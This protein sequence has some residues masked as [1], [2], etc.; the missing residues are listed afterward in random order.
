MSDKHFSSC[1]VVELGIQIEK[2]GKDFYGKLARMAQSKQASEVF[3]YLSEEEEK[4]IDIFK[5]IFKASCRYE[6][7]GAYPEDYFSYMNT[8][9]GE[10][11][12]TRKDKGKEVAAG[13]KSDIEAVTLGIKLEEESVTF[14]ENMKKIVSA[15]EA[16]TIDKLIKEEESHIKKLTDLKKVLES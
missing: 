9:A 13:T 2:N 12:F 10:Y 15:G 3:V 8:L 11:V 5:D 7:S 6:P 4:H 16:E 1:E 14:Y